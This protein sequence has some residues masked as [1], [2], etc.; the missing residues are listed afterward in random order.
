VQANN[1]ALIANALRVLH[2]QADAQG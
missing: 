1:S 2:T